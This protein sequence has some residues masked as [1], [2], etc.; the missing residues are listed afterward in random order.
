MGGGGW[1]VERY[2]IIFMKS[3]FTH[4]VDVCCY[5]D[6]VLVQKQRKEKKETEKR[7]KKKINKTLKKEIVFQS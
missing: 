2:C 1:I 7:Q 6:V 3:F 5:Y 4:N